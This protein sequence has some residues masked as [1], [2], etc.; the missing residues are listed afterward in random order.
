M[1]SDAE[2]A[3]GSFDVRPLGPRACRIAVVSLLFNWPS[4]GGGAVHTFE[5]G[6]AL[7]SSGYSVRHFYTSYSPWAV[8]QVDVPTR[9]TRLPL[10]FTEEEWKPETIRDRF[11]DQVAQ[12]DPDFV[13]VTDSWNTKPLLCEAVCDWPYF[14][15]LAALES[16]CPLNNVRLAFDDLNGVVQCDQN[17]LSRPEVCRR[18]VA[19]FGSASGAL[20]RAERQLGGFDDAD[21]AMRL[22]KAFRGA[23]GVLVVNPLIAELVQPFASNVSVVPSGFDPARFPDTSDLGWPRGHRKQVLFAGVAGEFMKGLHVAREAAAVL[24][25]TR[26]DFELVVTSDPQLPTAPF[27][28]WIGWQSQAALPEVISNSHVVVF[29]TIAQ[30]ALG[31]TAVEAMACGRPVVASRI[32]GLPWV[33]EDEVTGLLFDPGDANGLARQLARLLDDDE[34]ACRLGKAGRKKFDIDFRW[35]QVIRRHYARLFGP[36]LVI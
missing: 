35:D 12:F 29:P 13:V 26:Q 4:R 8:G 33:V 9:P 32:G 10:I 28:R 2:V 34:F 15:R 22:Q 5:L 23:A 1:R 16:I 17:Q 31:R 24:W 20:H 7:L 3:P 6:E 25:R 14:V 18:C 11:R 30:E 27:E 36:S 21:Y 19:R